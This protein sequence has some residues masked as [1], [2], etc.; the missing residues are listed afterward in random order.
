MGN[1]KSNRTEEEWDK[2]EKEAEEA[3]KKDMQKLD[4]YD[5]A[6]AAFREAEFEAVYG[7]YNK[8]KN[9]Q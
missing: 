5:K 8:K 7:R 1:A 4:A 9:E 6:A 2:L 3:A